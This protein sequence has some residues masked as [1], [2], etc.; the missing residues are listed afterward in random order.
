MIWGVIAALCV[1]TAALKASGPLVLGDHQPS[2]AVLRVISL[3][4]PAVLT[5]LVVYESL[6]GK[7]GGVEVDERLVGVA[8][9]GVAIWLR[10]PMTAVIVVAA[11]A[12]A[13]A[14]VL[15]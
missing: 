11:A 12:T 3:V 14:R 9:A 7:T 10:A 2:G 1:G 6:A 13:L 8:A 15:T 4:A 5:G